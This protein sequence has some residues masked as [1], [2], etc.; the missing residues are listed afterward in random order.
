M[1]DYKE[2]I[3]VANNCANRAKDCAIC[4]YKKHPDGQDSCIEVMLRDLADALEQTIRERDAAIADLKYIA[5]CVHCR[6][7]WFNNGETE[8]CPEPCGLNGENWEWRG[9]QK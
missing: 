7:S 2:L 8:T 3:M 5:S 1:T 9:V 6:K 4:Y